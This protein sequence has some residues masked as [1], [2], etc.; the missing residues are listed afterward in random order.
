MPFDVGDPLGCFATAVRISL[1]Q[2]RIFSEQESEK[3]KNC[4]FNGGANFINNEENAVSSVIMMES[5]G[6]LKLS[7]PSAT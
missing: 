3:Q 2:Q 4:T 1:L 7:A 6:G 5:G